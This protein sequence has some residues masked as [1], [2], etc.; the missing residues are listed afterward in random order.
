MAAFYKN[1]ADGASKD[2]ALRQAKL[3]FLRNAD[4][5]K[6]DPFYWAGFVL[7]GDTEPV[8]DDSLV[9]A[10]LISTSGIAFLIVSVFAILRL[11]RRNITLKP[12]Q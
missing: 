8:N 1:L 6:S 11:K 12:L 5:I 3:D 7:I 9:T 2:D 10:A 4:N